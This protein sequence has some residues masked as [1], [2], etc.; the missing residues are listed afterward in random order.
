MQIWLLSTDFDDTFSFS[1]EPGGDNTFVI[2]TADFVFENDLA[3]ARN[4]INHQ[5]QGSWRKFDSD[6]YGGFDTKDVLLQTGEHAQAEGV[7]ELSRF[8]RLELGAALRDFEKEETED[9]KSF[10]DKVRIQQDNLKKREQQLGRRTARMEEGKLR[11]MANA[12]RVQKKRYKDAETKF[13]DINGR[14]KETPEGRYSCL[15][16]KYQKAFYI[17]DWTSSN[18]NF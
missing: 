16:A 3:E 12:K 6:G 17:C 10:D 14:A 18:I 11:A 8:E 2:R 5:Y 7:G 15:Y 9:Q 1:T 13:V 4:T